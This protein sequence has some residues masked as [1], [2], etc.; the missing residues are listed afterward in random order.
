M[1]HFEADEFNFIKGAFMSIDRRVLS[2]CCVC[3][4][5]CVRLRARVWVWGVWGRP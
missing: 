4:C 5:V 3:V 2:P 1:P